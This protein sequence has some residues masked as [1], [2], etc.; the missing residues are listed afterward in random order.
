M[1]EAKLSRAVPRLKAADARVLDRRPGL[2]VLV[3]YSKR[4]CRLP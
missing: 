3:A 4:V 2:S 1:S